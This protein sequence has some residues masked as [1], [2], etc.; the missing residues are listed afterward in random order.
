M[1]LC[2]GKR[3]KKRRIFQTQ[4]KGPKNAA[5]SGDLFHGDDDVALVHVVLFT[6]AIYVRFVV[7]VQVLAETFRV[8]PVLYHK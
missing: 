3:K 7:L 1:Q 2:C 5:V 8:I 4:V 6:G